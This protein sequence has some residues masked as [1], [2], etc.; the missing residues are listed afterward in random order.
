[1]TFE[2]KINTFPRMIICVGVRFSWRIS[3][4]R[5]ISS[6]ATRAYFHNKSIHLGIT[7]DIL[8]N[9]LEVLK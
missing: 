2:I 5:I 3:H 4:V 1:L 9:T 7:S 6:S 8:M